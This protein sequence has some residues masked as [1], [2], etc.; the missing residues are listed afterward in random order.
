MTTV[1]T[2]QAIVRFGDERLP[3]RFRESITITP[4]AE[5][6]LSD[7]H[8]AR[9]DKGYGRSPGFLAQSRLTDVHT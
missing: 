5:H 1:P 3:E 8:G 2:S 7:W 4:P 9:D 6:R